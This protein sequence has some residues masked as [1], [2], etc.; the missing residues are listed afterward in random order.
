MLDLLHVSLKLLAF[1]KH[2]FEF[3]LFLGV[4]F[5]D[6]SDVLVSLLDLTFEGLLLL[7]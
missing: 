2:Q 6:L 3:V 4:L 5:D 1:L 7:H